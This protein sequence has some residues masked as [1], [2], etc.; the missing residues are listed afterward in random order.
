V[1]LPIKM[2]MIKFMKQLL[3]L[4]FAALEQSL[5]KNST[6]VDTSLSYQGVNT[7]HVYTQKSGKFEKYDACNISRT[8]RKE[9]VQ[10]VQDGT[11]RRYIME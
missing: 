10:C 4:L 9:L 8:L 6:H 11:D 3:L 2:S 1:L 7:L 5:M